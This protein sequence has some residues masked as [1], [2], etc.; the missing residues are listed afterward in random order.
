MKPYILNETFLAK[1]STVRFLQVAVNPY[2]YSA[3]RH[4]PPKLNFYHNFFF[5]RRITNLFLALY[6]ALNTRHSDIIFCFLF[7]W[8]ARYDFAL[9][10]R[11]LRVYFYWLMTSQPF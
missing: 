6:C 4:K 5:E 10:I 7:V 9:K 2:V 3:T 8:K 1:I 11:L